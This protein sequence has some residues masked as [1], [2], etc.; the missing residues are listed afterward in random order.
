MGISKKIVRSLKFE[1][2]LG[3]V[4]VFAINS[5]NKDIL[6]LATM[7][8]ARYYKVFSVNQSK[9]NIFISCNVVF[10]EKNFIA[11]YAIHSWGFTFD[12]FPFHDM[13]I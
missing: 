4:L 11:M 6:V 12:N 7:S 3:N 8:S 10:L 5:F 2:I 1:L 9:N 13:K